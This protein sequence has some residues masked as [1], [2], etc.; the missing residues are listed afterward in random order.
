MP[1]HIGALAGGTVFD[2]ESIGW[3]TLFWAEGTEFKA[4]GYVHGDDLSTVPDEFGAAAD[5]ATVTASSHHEY[6]TNTAVFDGE[7]HMYFS[8]STSGNAITTGNFVKAAP[9]AQYTLVVIFW[10]IDYAADYQ[11]LLTDN[12]NSNQLSMQIYPS[13]NNVR[14]GPN[15]SYLIIADDAPQAMCLYFDTAVG[16]NDVVTNN[17]VSHANTPTDFAVTTPGGLAL[18]ARGADN[19]YE[20]EGGIAMVGIYNGDLRAHDD[21]V[22]LSAWCERKYGVPL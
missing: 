17:G 9:T 21:W 11:Y 20:F 16:G 1:T 3:H 13:S 22:S 6:R 2:P 5:D 14:L 7:P 10:P 15:A 4:Q 18:G 8:G 19:Q 12:D